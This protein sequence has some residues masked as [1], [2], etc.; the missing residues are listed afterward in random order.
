MRSDYDAAGATALQCL[1]KQSTFPFPS[2]AW[3]SWMRAAMNRWY[4]AGTAA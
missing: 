2:D 1:I 4:P 3:L